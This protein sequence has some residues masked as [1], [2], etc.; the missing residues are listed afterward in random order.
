[1]DRQDIQA[2]EVDVELIRKLDRNGPRY[3]SYPTA[4]RFVEAFNADSYQSW[5]AKR[6]LGGVQRP[7]SIY[8]H[9]PFCNTLCFYCGCNK[10][11][12]KD[13]SKAALY[14]EYLKKEIA[15]QGALFQ[16]DSLVTQLHFGGGTP[17]FLSDEQMSELMA[18]IRSHFRL[19]EGGE[20]SIE[21][22][23]RKVN[24]QTIELLGDLGFNRI[25]LGVQDFDP[26]VQKAVNRIQSVEET[27][28]VIGAAR[29]SGFASVSI[30]L[31]YGLPKQNLTG[32]SH[33]LDRVI[34][35]DP[36][37]LAIYNY[38]HLP[39]LFKPQRRI[40]EDDLPSADTK[41]QIMS[42]AIQRMTA[43][44]YVYIGMDHF[45]KPDDELAVAQRMGRLHRNFQ[46][47][48]THADC[49]LVALGVTAIGKVGP[50]YSQNFRTLEEYYDSLDNDELPIMRGLELS[51]DDL[52]RRDIIQ[53]LMCHFALSKESFEIAY[54]I[55]FDSYFEQE[56]TE[57]KTYQGYGLVKLENGWITVTPKGRLLIR[58][59]GMIFDKYLR[60]NQERKMYSKVI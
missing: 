3:T 15:M 5:V 29:R 55:D 8:V 11:I 34:A 25:S 37:R 51:A 7:L 38:A 12:T 47:Y 2:L 42:M 33:T 53:A 32:F 45:A 23:P 4:D 49:D 21:I 31:I 20:Y 17:T 6:N 18:T 44:G 40:N 39:A 16:G 48:S 30:D 43:A 13:K 22:D 60:I 1:M 10:V 50:T 35:A 46:G 19:V 54:L 52:L 36:D 24:A 9:I 56:L 28:S 57:L 41:L 14:L 59:I 58:N 27:W 26:D